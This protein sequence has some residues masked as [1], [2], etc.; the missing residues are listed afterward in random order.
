VLETGWAS[1]W[2]D[3]Q[4]HKVYK[5][6]GWPYNGNDTSV[7]STFTPTVYGT[8]NWTQ[9][10]DPAGNGLVQSNPS[11]FSAAF[12]T[13]DTN[14]YSLGGSL[15]EPSFTP[16]TAVQGLVDYNF[17]TNTWT[18]ES[19]T[20]AT[21]SGLLVSGGAAYASGFGKAGFLIFLGGL[22]PSTQ[23]F[24]PS[25]AQ[26]ADM[27]VI[28]LYDISSGKWYHQTATGTIPPPRQFFCLV[29]SSS[30]EGSFEM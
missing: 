23:V 14:F 8:V 19:S 29:G 17:V 15:G 11:I 26:L 24:E 22:V 25:G 10:P 4:N 20:S 2:Y 16:F 18:N 30:T 12:V 3:Q 27:S 9:A 6:G 7:L 5:W 13:S 1:L 21:Q 28:I